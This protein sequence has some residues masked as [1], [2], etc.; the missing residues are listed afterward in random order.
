LCCFADRSAPADVFRL[1]LFLELALALLGVDHC[2]FRLLDI[3]PGNG[4]AFRGVELCPLDVVARLHHRG[5]ILFASDPGLRVG[6]LDFR[7]RLLQLR[8]L[9]LNRSLEC[10]WIEL[11]QQ[12]A[13]L[14]HR[15]AL[16]QFQYLQF[17]RLH[18]R[19]QHD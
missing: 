16:G 14:H 8:L 2:Q 15:S 13:G 10:R 18:G 17:P 19:R 1:H 6:L 5:R 3:Q 9:L 7:V 12:I 11:H 4:V